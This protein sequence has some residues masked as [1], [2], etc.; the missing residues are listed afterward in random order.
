ME[1]TQTGL[2]EIIYFNVQHIR[3]T[4]MNIKINIKIDKICDFKI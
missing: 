1:Q 3:K 2:N 4:R